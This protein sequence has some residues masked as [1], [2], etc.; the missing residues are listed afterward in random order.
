M[1]MGIPLS[2]GEE[3]A[4]SS[5]PGEERAWPGHVLASIL[6]AA[7]LKVKDFLKNPRYF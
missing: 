4:R 5:S 7:G 6:F 3:T 1:V 2:P